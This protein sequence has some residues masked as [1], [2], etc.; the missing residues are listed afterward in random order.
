MLGNYDE[1]KETIGETPISK[2]MNKG[3][4]SSSSEEKSSQ[5]LYGEQRGGG[6]G[7]GGGSSGGGGQSSK[8]TP[9]GSASSAS[10]S[11]SSSSQMQKRSGLQ[12]SQRSAGGSGSSSSSSSQRHEKDYSSSSSGKKSS[13]HS[14]SDQSKGHTSS[15][16]KGS[17][18][19]SS[20]H[21]RSLGGS[22]H[23][24]KDRYRKSPRDREREP[25]WDSPSRV[26]TSSFA[27][28]QHSSQAFPPSL[29]TKPSSMLQKPTA[30]VRP[31]DGQET[32]EPKGSSEMYSG[33]S[34][35]SSTG[36]MKSNGKASLAKLKIPTQ[37]VEVQLNF[38]HYSVMITIIWLFYFRDTAPSLCS[39]KSFIIH[40]PNLTFRG[41]FE[42]LTWLTLK[43]GV[44]TLLVGWQW[45]VLKC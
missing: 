21:S 15:P 32:A 17:S 2:H 12:S 11:S 37:P 20:G 35:S 22:E 6:G 40:V 19:N 30:Y 24:G 7:G 9:V 25:S 3:S 33:Q 23:H 10:S 29:M 42:T 26:L 5:G 27:T 38:V 18:M 8:W 43:L 45:A 13:K 31:M 14:S 28:G 44:Q 34:H 36:E 39:H 4:S 1:M 16:A 41:A